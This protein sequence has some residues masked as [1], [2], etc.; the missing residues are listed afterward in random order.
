MYVP[1]PYVGLL[2]G[3]DLTLVEEWNCLRGAIVDAASKAACRPII[4]WLR[5]AIIRSGPGTYSALVIPEP[6]APLPDALFLQHHHRILLIH[7]TGLDR[8]IN[9]AAG[10]RIAETVREVAVELRETQTENKRIWDKK[11]N[12][13][14]SD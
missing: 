14:A 9:R 8:S 4:D 12:K 11:R 2:L 5:A 7:L 10:T 1:D 6:L 13:G 3:N